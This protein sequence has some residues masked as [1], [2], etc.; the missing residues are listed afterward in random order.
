MTSQHHA[1]S[2]DIGIS[3]IDQAHILRSRLLDTFAILETNVV[4]LLAKSDKNLVADTAP[5][6]QRIDALKKLTLN[7][8]PTK[9]CSA[10]LAK[11]CSE[12]SPYL[13]IRSDVVH[14][15]LTV[16]IC[17]D[18][19]HAKFCNTANEEKPFPEVRLLAF[20]DFDAIGKEV[21][22]LSNQLQSILTPPPSQ[23]QPKPAAKAGP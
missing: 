12:I 5:L 11:I 21:R 16:C 23:P 3:P 17:D 6:G 13:V 9:N 2:T 19:P 8:A 15:K 7:P 22:R 20:E 1:F 18:K 4:K 14:A 10:K